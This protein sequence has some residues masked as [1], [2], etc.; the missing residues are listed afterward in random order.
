VFFEDST[1]IFDLFLEADKNISIQNFKEMDT[2]KSPKSFF[3]K[4]KVS[5]IH[6]DQSY[7]KV[8]LRK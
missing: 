3:I 5:K 2:P 1:E 6:K 7:Q 4:R 8:V